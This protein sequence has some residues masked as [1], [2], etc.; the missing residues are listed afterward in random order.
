[1]LSLG[2]SASTLCWEIVGDFRC[3]QVRRARHLS[4][5]IFNSVGLYRACFFILFFFFFFF[6]WAVKASL[7]SYLSSGRVFIYFILYS[8]SLS[9]HW[10]HH[11]AFPCLG[12][13]SF[14]CP[15]FWAPVFY[16]QIRFGAGDGERAQ[17][18]GKAPCPELSTQVIAHF[19]FISPQIIA[20]R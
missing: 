20:G 15:Q 11:A 10:C 12:P 19:A 5:H 4:V 2:A 7:V 13:P 16:G 6:S 1:M 17:G 14:F 3:P 9:A 8:S 18:N